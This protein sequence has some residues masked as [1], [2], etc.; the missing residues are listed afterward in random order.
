MVCSAGEIDSGSA[1]L[2]GQG[3]HLDAAPAPDHQAAP[4]SSQAPHRGRMW[5]LRVCRPPR[6]CRAVPDRPGG[7]RRPSRS[8]ASGRP[9]GGRRRW[10]GGRGCAAGRR[11]R[12]CRPGCARPAASPRSCPPAAAARPR[13]AASG[14]RAAI[15][16]PRSVRNQARSRPACGRVTSSTR[17]SSFSRRSRRRISS[18]RLPGVRRM[19]SCS[20]VAIRNWHS[21]ATTA[22]SISGGVAITGSSTSVPTAPV[23]GSTRR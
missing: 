14:K 3:E 10:P 7:P 20:A 23:A 6:W 5:S 1:S 9:A 15:R 21:A 12:R 8:S 22:W 13:V 2:N 11:A 17:P 16:A 18:G 19:R 4:Y